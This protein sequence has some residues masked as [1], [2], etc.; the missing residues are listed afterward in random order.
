MNNL[1]S[2]QHNTIPLPA[3]AVIRADKFEGAA[4]M[5]SAAAVVSGLGTAENVSMQQP[6]Q[7]ELKMPEVNDLFSKGRVTKWFPRQGYG[8]VTDKNNREVY[9]SLLEMDFVGEKGKESLKVGAFV[10]FDPSWTSHGLH[11]KHMKVY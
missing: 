3:A 8:I 11:I 5:A 1:I 2:W 10:G 6:P 9:F 4:Q 7:E